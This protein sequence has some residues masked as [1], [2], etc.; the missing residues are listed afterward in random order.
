[1]GKLIDLLNE[2]EKEHWY[3]EGNGYEYRYIDE[4]WISYKPADK[5]CEV[6]SIDFTFWKKFIKWLVDNDK[7]AL[8]RTD[9]YMLKEIWFS[10]SESLLMLLSIQKE[11]LE[12][13]SSIL[14]EDR[15]QEFEELVDRN[16]DVAKRLANLNNYEDM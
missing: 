1:M 16:I 5:D 6:F 3:S 8:D 9:V 12:F 7:I 15:R 14:L 4:D 13:L 11:P 10:D 2:F